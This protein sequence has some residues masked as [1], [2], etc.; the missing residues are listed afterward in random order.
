[1]AQEI[2]IKVGFGGQF[3]ELTVRIRMTTSSRGSR[4]TPAPDWRCS[5]TVTRP[6]R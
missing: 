5:S 3:R 6:P 1:M 4:R 2:T